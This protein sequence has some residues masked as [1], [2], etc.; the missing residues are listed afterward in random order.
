VH[1]R[2]DQLAKLANPNLTPKQRA[3]LRLQLCAKGR[4]WRA[5][6]AVWRQL[7]QETPALADAA[8]A[9][10][11]LLVLAAATLQQLTRAEK[12]SA[13][14]E[15]CT[16]ITENLRAEDFTDLRISLALAQ[17]AMRVLA[18]DAA[19]TPPL[20]APVRETLRAH[21]LKTAPEPWRQ[22]VLETK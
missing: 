11:E 17:A 22:A 16:A 10:R 20:P 3:V 12:P 5:G 18:K 8:P 14:A 19:F 13:P 7:V 1:F 21:L 4:Q 2:Q 9:R 15:L 6:L